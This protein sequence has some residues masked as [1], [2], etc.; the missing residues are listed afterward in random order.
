M[1]LNVECFMVA[2]RILRSFSR[3]KYTFNKALI[4][5]SLRIFIVLYFH[6]FEIIRIYK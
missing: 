3:T 5:N 1:I 4:Y 6:S 2:L